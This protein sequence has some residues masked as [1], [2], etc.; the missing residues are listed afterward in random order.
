MPDAPFVYDLVNTDTGERVWQPDNEE[1][2]NMVAFEPWTLTEEC[3]AR[4]KKRI[5]TLRK[6]F[7]HVHDR[8]FIVPGAH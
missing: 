4:L 1:V 3:D 5:A 8:Q 6:L 7:R 2:T